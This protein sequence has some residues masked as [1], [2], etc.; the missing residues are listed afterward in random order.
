MVI[1][2]CTSLRGRKKL[3]MIRIKATVIEKSCKSKQG[4]DT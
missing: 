1:G 3:K 4:A 2:K